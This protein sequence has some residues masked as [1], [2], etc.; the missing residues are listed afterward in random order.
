MSEAYYRD[1]LYPLQDAALEAI[2][3]TSTRLYLTGGTLLSRFMLNHR[4]SDDLDF[5]INRDDHFELEVQKLVDGL[6]PLGTIRWGLR[7][8]SFTRVF[9]EHKGVTLKLEFV[10]DILHH[11]GKIERHSSGF[12]MDNWQNVLT[13]K[14]TALSRLA[15]KDYID[16]LFLSL[17]FPF[18]WEEMINHAKQKDAWISEHE[19]AN[20]LLKFD[21]NELAQ[22][23]FSDNFNK[24]TITK[25]YFEILA[26]DSFNGFDN[27]LYGQTLN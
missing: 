9:L 13:N 6:T 16:I 10:N 22:V 11:V 2:G 1:Q 15:A 18:N 21:S 23:V 12:L 27:S 17:S 20:F 8:D 25:S 14:I 26:R 5:F 19:I 4:L 7:D 3:K 24:S